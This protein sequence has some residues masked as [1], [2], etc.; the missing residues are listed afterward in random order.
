MA[1]KYSDSVVITSDN[2]RTEEPQAI[3]QDILTG[4]PSSAKGKVTVLADRKEAIH[5]TLKKAQ[6][7]DVILIAGKGHEDYQI[8]GTTKFPFSDVQVAQEAMQGRV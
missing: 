5:T 2:P 1:L 3:I 6:P 7:G 4:V 8:I